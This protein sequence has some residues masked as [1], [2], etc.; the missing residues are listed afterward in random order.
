MR[1][2]LPALLV[3]LVWAAP[4]AARADTPTPAGCVLALPGISKL[5]VA[6]RPIGYSNNIACIPNGDA[7]SNPVIEW[8]DGTTSVGT[9]TTH[10]QD[11]VVVAGTH[12]Y[13]SPGVFKIRAKVTNAVSGQTYSQ[14]SEMEADIRPAPLSATPAQCGAPVSEPSKNSSLSAV[15]CGFKTRSGSPVRSYEVALIRARMPS[16]GLRATI[17]WGDGT[18]STGAV[19][20][21]GT[22][23]VSGRHRWQHSGRYAVVATLTDASGHVVAQATGYAVVVARK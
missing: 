18:K 16:A 8:G 2:W 15:G 1:R 10:A 19:T 17:S 13:K 7:V 3:G 9:I 14:G 22:L 20:G 11:R 12:V 6:G 23:H 4:E 21:T 5:G